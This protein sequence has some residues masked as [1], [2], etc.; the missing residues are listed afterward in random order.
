MADWQADWTT[1]L[2][3][4]LH[5]S[6]S[7]T[8]AFNRNSRLKIGLIRISISATMSAVHRFQDRY[9]GRKDDP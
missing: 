8:T 9:I 6:S 5:G 3:V 4:A 1:G 7:S 2:P